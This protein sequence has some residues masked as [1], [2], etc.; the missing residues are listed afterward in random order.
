MVIPR[1]YGGPKI[2]AV[3]SW[4]YELRVGIKV[5]FQNRYGNCVCVGGGGVQGLHSFLK[6]LNIQQGLT[7]ILWSGYLN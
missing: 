6:L 2:F 5:S 4:L 1:K 3:E 7:F